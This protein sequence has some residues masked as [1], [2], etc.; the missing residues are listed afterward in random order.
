MKDLLCFS[1]PNLFREL[2][3]LK[4]MSIDLRGHWKGKMC[5]YIQ[6]KVCSVV[7]EPMPENRNVFNR[8][9]QQN[10]CDV[11][12]TFFVFKKE[13]ILMTCYYCGNP[14]GFETNGKIIRTT[15]VCPYPQGIQPFT[16]VLNV[17]SGKI[18]FANVLHNW[19]ETEKIEE[20][21][22]KFD[23]NSEIGLKD[24]SKFY[25]RF[26]MITCFC[27]NTCPGIYT[28]DNKF[29]LVVGNPGNIYDEEFKRRKETL[30]PGKKVGKIITDLWWWCAVDYDDL[31]S[32]IDKGDRENNAK[33]FTI[34]D[35]EPGK[36]E[37]VQY[38]H[39]LD[40]NACSEPQTYAT[41]KKI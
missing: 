4:K 37:I 39:T 29:S 28:I 20:E 16:M 3:K 33:H 21:A 1:L 11:L 26:G 17:P 12:D 34:I 41:I 35:V 36:Y 19:Y 15:S 9:I 6:E 31:M 13:S 2:L 25:E 5:D 24:Y 38:Y 10:Y 14:I 32:R 7:L 40:K 8:W 23:I 22:D 30:Y 27:G 18:V